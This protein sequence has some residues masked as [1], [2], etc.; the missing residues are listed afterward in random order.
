MVQGRGHD[1]IGDTMKPAVRIVLQV[2]LIAAALVFGA[3]ALFSLFK[4]VQQGSCASGGNR[5]SN[6]QCS[7]D[8]FK[9][10]W[11]L[12]GG[13][14]GCLFSFLAVMMMSK[15]RLPQST[16]HSSFLAPSPEPIL[17][18][19]PA[20]IFGRNIRVMNAS[21]LFGQQTHA[22]DDLVDQLQGLKALFDDGTLSTSEYQKAKDRLLSER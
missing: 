4:L 15:K 1:D 3:A 6:H 16:E 8:S 7:P 17:G 5:V 10:F 19:N 11:I 21:E 14:I 18:P 2:I 12:P 20:A 9:Y 22:P 13:I